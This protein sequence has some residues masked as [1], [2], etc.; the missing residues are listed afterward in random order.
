MTYTKE[1]ILDEYRENGHASFAICEGK[2]RRKIYEGKDMEEGEELLDRF[3]SKI[4]NGNFKIK[5]YKAVPKSGIDDK[6]P[7]FLSL[8]YE[9]RYSTESKNQYWQEKGLGGHMMD[10]IRSLRSEIS[11]LKTQ[12]EESPT[13]EDLEQEAKPEGIVG[14]ILGNPAIQSV[15]ASL[16]TN[17]ASNWMTNTNHV[18]PHQQ[19]Y[20]QVRPQAMAGVD[21]DTDRVKVAVNDVI[22][23]ELRDIIQSLINKGVTIAD[24]QKLDDMPEAK[25]NMLLSMLRA[26]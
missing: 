24:F 5:L 13:D 25:L 11:G 14:A 26:Q 6:T 20:P 3:L 9:V 12:L 18:S 15:L 10:E 22:N 23:C 19:Q 1:S 2:E 16:L 21:G 17:M 7:V 4:E 8:P